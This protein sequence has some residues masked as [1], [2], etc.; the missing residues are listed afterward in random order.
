VRN[1]EKILPSPTRRLRQQSKSGQVQAEQTGQIASPIGGNLR[2]IQFRI[3]R[4]RAR[5]VH[6]R[7]G[8]CVAMA[9]VGYTNSVDRHIHCNASQFVW[10]APWSYY[11]HKSQRWKRLA[12]MRQWVRYKYNRAIDKLGLTLERKWTP[13]VRRHTSQKLR[14]H[15]KLFQLHHACNTRRRKRTLRISRQIQ[16]ALIANQVLAQATIRNRD[17]HSQAGTIRHRLGNDWGAQSLL[18]MHL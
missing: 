3:T 15:I 2:R 11:I 6:S 10:L 1:K 14:H 9:M 18:C 16:R 8:Y 13:E 5:R 4:T 12:W 17:R 7:V